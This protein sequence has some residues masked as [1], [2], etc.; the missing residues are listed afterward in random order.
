MGKQV[1][2]NRAYFARKVEMLRTVNI[3]GN[4][5]QGGKSQHILFKCMLDALEL[6]YEENYELADTVYDFFVDSTLVYISPT[7]SCSG[8]VYGTDIKRS[9][10][11]YLNAINNGYHY[12]QIFDW[13]NIFNC[14][15][16]LQPRQTISA[17][18]CVVSKL[19]S[20]EAHA[21]LRMNSIE[22]QKGR[23]FCAN[24]IGLYYGDELVQVFTYLNS[25]WSSI[26]PENRPDWTI[27]R[28]CTSHGLIVEGGSK[29]LF[30]YF[31]ENEC[32]EHVV[33]YFNCSKAI[34]NEYASTGM[35][36]VCT[37]NPTQTWSR[38][39]EAVQE[40]LYKSTG[41]YTKP[42]L[43]VLNG[44]LPIHDCGKEKYEWRRGESTNGQH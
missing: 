14:S 21:F 36:H 11:R 6:E 9:Y 26:K 18:D 30:N 42:Q 41:D 13:D 24:P 27:S 12:I 40:P 17:D 16:A 19:G 44:W 28:I 29:K 2:D 5:F 33:G 37:L 32:P 20:I 34:I 1:A 10:R 39:D 7:L 4:T 8:L 38:F 15:L 31:I 43:M 3:Y 35:K 25:N 23:H 22:L